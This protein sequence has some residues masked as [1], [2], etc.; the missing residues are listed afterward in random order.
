M[1]ILY[2]KIKVQDKSGKI[3]IADIEEYTR[4]GTKS[5]D[6]WIIILNGKRYT[7]Y[8]QRYYGIYATFQTLLEIIY[9]PETIRNMV[10][11]VNPFMNLIPKDNST[12][13]R[14]PSVIIR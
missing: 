13:Q 14:Y 2:K 4:G 12:G 1:M 9:P 5:P 6:L 8:A 11:N 7:P 3:L 10:Y